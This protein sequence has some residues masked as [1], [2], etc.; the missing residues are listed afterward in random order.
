MVHYY[1]PPL[2]GIGSLRARKFVQYLPQFGWEPTVVA[3]R[4]GSYFRDS[5]LTVEET[6]VVRTSSVELSRIGKRVVTGRIHDT[7]PARVGRVGAW[8]RDLARS[9]IYRPDAQIGWYPFALAAARRI[10]TTTRFDVVFSSSMPVT[11]HLVARRIAQETGLPWIAE[12]RDPW[13]DVLGSPDRRQAA[14]LVERRIVTAASAVVT[15]SPTLERI[16]RGKGARRTLVVMNG[17]DPAD[18]VPL[19]S[20]SRF[21]VT[22]SGSYYPQ[23]QDLRCVWQALRSLRE[24]LPVGIVVVG[25]LHESI[26]ADLEACRLLDLVEVTGFVP[27]REALRRLAMSSV[28]LVAGTA[29][30]HSVYDC[31]LPAKLFEYLGTGLPLL[32]VGTRNSDAGE[33]LCRYPGCWMV[34][35]GDTQGAAAALRT[36]RA[37]PACAP[38]ELETISRRYLTG[39]LAGLLDEVA[40]VALA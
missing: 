18:M 36:I 29:R 25:E 33:L 40:A 30:S 35:A 34:N 24:T 6:R 39:R 26:R 12:F 22:Y 15:I 8:L 32:Y 4:H 28:L 14:D 38:R 16:W 7:Q 2:G 31:V 37:S 1:F 3:P 23:M 10:L 13:A 27:Y 9:W 11:A 5:S 17:F 21:I 20:P 19:E